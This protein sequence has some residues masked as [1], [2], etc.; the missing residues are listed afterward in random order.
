M[1]ENIR[2]NT[3]VRRQEILGT[4]YHRKK[5]FLIK[6]TSEHFLSASKRQPRA[7]TDRFSTFSLF[8]FPKKKFLFVGSTHKQEYPLP[9][10]FY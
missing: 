7:S 6:V 10:H 3:F 1:V 9:Q 2:Y 4:Y 8:H 5:T